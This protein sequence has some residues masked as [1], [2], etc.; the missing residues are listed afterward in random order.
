M[1][2]EG[3]S[4]SALMLYID[5]ATGSMLFTI[6]F[7]IIGAAIY[8]LRGLFLKLRFRLSGG[9]ADISISKT[10]PIA[11]YSDDKRYWN[12]FKPI[13][14]EFDR[15]H[16]SVVYMTSSPDDPALKENFENI[17]CEFIGEGNKG[18]A[19]L[20]MLHASILLSTT[21]GLDVYQ[22][23]RSKGTDYYVHITHAPSDIAMYRMFG[24]DYYDAVLLSGEY[25]ATQIRELEKLRGLSPKELTIVGLPYMDVM[26]QRAV[27]S[28]IDS[29][30]NTTVLL[31]PS[32][33]ES[34]ILKKYG[35]TIIDALIDTGFHIIIRPHPQSF[36]SEADMI[37]HLM[38]Q[39]RDC[40]QIEWNRDLDNFDVL[41]RADILISDFSGVIFDFCLVFDK[42][43]I[44]TEAKYDKSPYDACWLREELWTFTTLPHIGSQLKDDNI[45]NIKEVIL[46]CLTNTKF[47]EARDQARKETWM[48]MGK[49]AQRTVDYIL[50]KYAEIQHSKE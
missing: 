12:I 9:K 43:V 23:K 21:P 49:G 4:Y 29:Q 15:R 1:F 38:N 19:K 13:C 46:D 47:K 30:Q 32:W 35:S 16:Q 44:Y 8:A 39:Y 45:S 18:F 37:E 28:H 6:V 17:K 31:A 7:G 5:P 2:T 40:G 24:I 42:P 20:N 33:G 26:K 50:T 48:Y 41:N 10:I 25:Q 3:T 11:I 34:A 27:T 36:K 22:W 14:D